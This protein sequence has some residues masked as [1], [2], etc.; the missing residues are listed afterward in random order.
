MCFVLIVFEYCNWFGSKLFVSFIKENTVTF[1]HSCFY[2]LLHSVTLFCVWVCGCVWV[3]VQE[4][5]GL[6]KLRNVLLLTPKGYI[7]L[8][9]GTKCQQSRCKMW[10]V[11]VYFANQISST[12][13]GH[14]TQI[15]KP[16]YS[17]DGS[18]M[19]NSLE[20]GYQSNTKEI[21]KKNTSCCVTVY[22]T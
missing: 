21:T 4:H 10:L 15:S 9:R 2:T 12:R 20:Q 6:K 1:L 3:C 7:T 19:T 13:L 8:F 17:K 18:K 11:L 5:Y 16:V 14:L 22:H